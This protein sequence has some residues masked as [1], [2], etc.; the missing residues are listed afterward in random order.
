ME[1]TRRMKLTRRTA[2]TFVCLTALPLP[3]RA[4]GCLPLLPGLSLCDTTDWRLDTIEGTT[5][6]LIH[7]SGLAAKV[8]F[9]TGRSEDDLMWDGWQATHAPISARAEVLDV[10][11]TEVIGLTGI[12]TAY[13][14]RHLSPPTVVVLSSAQ[15]LGRSIRVTSQSYGT[16]FSDQHRRAVAALLAAL[17]L[18]PTE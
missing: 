14:P 13:L 4:G 17:Q 18:D 9:L 1:R 7:A 5:A 3:L 2:L 15:G 10:S 12:T 8:T 16:T 11:F 6:S